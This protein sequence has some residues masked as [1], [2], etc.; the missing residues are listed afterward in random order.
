[1]LMMYPRSGLGTKYRFCPSNL[2]GIID[3]DYAESDNEGHI[4][5]KMVNDGLKVVDLN[6]GKAFCQGILLRYGVTKDDDT[7]TQRNGGFGS[8]N[9]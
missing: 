8:T 3:A 4:F 9:N 2:T 1:V 7:N 5:M 6:K